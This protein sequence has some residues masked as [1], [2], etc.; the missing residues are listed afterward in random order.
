MT[1]I[2]TLD[3]NGCKAL[4]KA[5]DEHLADFEAKYGVKLTAGNM[6]FHHNGKQASVKL[7][8]VV[9]DESGK[10]FDVARD[11]FNRYCGLLGFKPEDWD[12]PF[13]I[14]GT[15]YRLCGLKMSS[16]KFPILGKTSSGKVYKFVAADVIRTMRAAAA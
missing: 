3:R 8:A 9:V 7:E 5:L 4:R 2:T 15:E 16:R 1:K 12:K 10:A 6:T 13:W 11:E 14:N